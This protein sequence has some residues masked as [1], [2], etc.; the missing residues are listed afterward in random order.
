[1]FIASFYKFVQ[2]RELEE[3]R[4]SVEQTCRDRGVKGTII[5]A[6]EGINA[7]IGA[8]S[9][10]DLESCLDEILGSLSLG[11][12]LINRSKSG[13][14]TDVFDQLIV[15]VRGEIVTFGESFDFSKPRLPKAD[16]DYWNKMLNDPNC[17]ILDVRNEY[18]VRLGRFERSISPKTHSFGEFRDWAENA[19]PKLKRNPIGIYCTGGIRCEKAA[20]L[21]DESGFERVTQLDG[22]ILNYLASKPDSSHW[23]GECFVFDK[24]VSVDADLQ[25][26]T[27]TQCHACR[28][29]LSREDRETDH[30]EEGISC[31]H[32]WNEI[33]DQRREGLRER[34]KQ[35]AIAQ[36]RNQYHIGKKA[37][38]VDPNNRSSPS[39]QSSRE[40]S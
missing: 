27:A 12:L 6:T 5:L 33:P 13:P 16:S 9:E 25:E 24:R 18:E 34:A 10:K 20:Q 30:Y 14:T 40:R 31:P 36:E 19:H 8:P 38:P 17:S 28:R 1:M 32:C 2:L 23:T 37:Q 22:G 11:N 35:M 15:R 7:S 39:K 21:L 29:P 4:A 3:L 26:G